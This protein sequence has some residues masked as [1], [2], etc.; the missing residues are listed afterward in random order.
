MMMALGELGLA[1]ID[2]E[3]GT[4]GFASLLI[5]PPAHTIFQGTT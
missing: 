1:M 3:G 5:F 2:E 4:L